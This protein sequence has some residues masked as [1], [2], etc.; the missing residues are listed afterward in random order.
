M[1]SISCTLCP[2]LEI[3]VKLDNAI[4]AFSGKISLMSSK[5]AH[6]SI[7]FTSMTSGWLQKSFQAGYSGEGPCDSSEISQ[8]SFSCS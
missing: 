8:R 7:V 4:A 3:E 1:A 6:P 5:V 2:W